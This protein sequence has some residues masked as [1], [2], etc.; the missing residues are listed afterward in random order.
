M[1]CTLC[2][3]GSIIIILHAP[4][5]KDIQTV[6]EILQYAI[7]PGMSSTSYAGTWFMIVSGFLLYSLVVLI[8]SLFMIYYVAPKYGTKIPLVYI[9]ICSVVGSMSVMAIKGFGIALKLTL[10]GNNQLT[11]PS[12]YVFGIV[13]VVCILVQM[14]YFNKALA[15]FSTNVYVSIGIPVSRC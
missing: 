13:V 5:D 8:F 2:V 15:I 4:E 7:Q 1:G 10:A 6:D 12:T 11:H 9:S 3:L 14:N